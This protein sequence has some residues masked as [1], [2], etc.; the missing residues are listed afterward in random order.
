MKN[1]L[2]FLFSTLIILALVAGMNAPQAKAP[3]FS[4]QDNNPL[5]AEPK[6]E[7]LPECSFT[8][9]TLELKQ[10]E[11]VR[12]SVQNLQTRDQVRILLDDSAINVQ[13]A[14][15]YAENTYLLPFSYSDSPG[16]KKLLLQ[17]FRD[18]EMI[19]EEEHL[20]RLLEEDFP[21]QVLQ[22]SPSMQRLIG[23]EERDMPLYQGL[24]ARDSA[25]DFKLWRDDFLLPVEGRLSTPF[26]AIRYEETAEP[27]RH[28]GIDLATPA[29]T[30]IKATNRGIVVFATEDSFS[31]NA[32]VLEHGGGLYS[33]YY[34]LQSIDVFFG[35]LIEQGEVIGTVGSTGY[36]TGPHLH[37]AIFINGSFINPLY[38]LGSE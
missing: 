9:S 34:H 36:S 13:A 1:R 25:I 28:S 37:F 30:P 27:S 31:G 3:D 32:V 10:G 23:E 11:F 24:A 6:I 4:E 8:V 12:I 16:E 22:L 21:I 38:L 17:I 26:G 18:A 15:T 7:T 20:I 29:G 5:L 14:K 2:I 19:L 35:Q 33:L